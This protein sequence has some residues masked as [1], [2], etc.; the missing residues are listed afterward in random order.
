MIC[1]DHHICDCLDMQ[2]ADL[3]MKAKVQAKTIC[4]F[5]DFI[6]ESRQALEYYANNIKP[7][8]ELAKKL[9]EKIEQLRIG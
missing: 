1:R 4:D 3:E 9:L 5:A 8:Q 6:E 2:I 7:D